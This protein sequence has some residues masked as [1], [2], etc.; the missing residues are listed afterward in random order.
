MWDGAF[1][2]GDF[3]IGYDDH[4]DALKEIALESFEPGGDVPFHR[5]WY[6]RRD[7]DVVWDRELRVDRLAEVRGASLLP[8]ER[9]VPQGSRTRVKQ[10]RASASFLCPHCAS[11]VDT[12][13][14]AG[15]GARQQYVEDCPVCCRP[16]K[17]A[18]TWVD[19]QGGFVVQA[20]ADE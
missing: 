3:V 16:N 1:S 13:P 6:I 7:D 10:P 15:G 8:P 17:I 20:V 14:D 12:S 2:P 9:T 11:E 18:A 5:I 19:A 4:D